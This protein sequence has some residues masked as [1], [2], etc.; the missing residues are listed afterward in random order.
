MR[1]PGVF[2]NEGQYIFNSIS[3]GKISRQVYLSILGICVLLIYEFYNSYA[4]VFIFFRLQKLPTSQSEERIKTILWWNESPDRVE[5]SSFGKGQEAFVSQGCDYTQCE[6]VT[7]ISERPF[8][9]Y[10]A[11]IFNIPDLDSR[12]ITDM[13]NIRKHFLI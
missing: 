8:A 1:W 10:D 12:F 5:L 9:T 2:L 6:I 3:T 11:I 4:D 13:H 7:N